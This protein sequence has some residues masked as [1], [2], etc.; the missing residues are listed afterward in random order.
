MA[1]YAATRSSVTAMPFHGCAPGSPTSW[2]PGTT[3]TGASNVCTRA[4]AAARS[5]ATS[6][7]RITTS[8]VC[9][10]RSGRSSSLT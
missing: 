1:S 9:T 2:L 8:P 6:G 3:R 7:S 10:T 5:S 4:C